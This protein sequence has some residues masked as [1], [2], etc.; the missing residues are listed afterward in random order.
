MLVFVFSGFGYSGFSSRVLSFFGVGFWYLV[1]FESV[2]FCCFGFCMGTLIFFSFGFIYSA[3]VLFFCF[4]ILWL[5]VFW[6]SE[7]AVLC[8]F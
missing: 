2:A 8:W 7:L 5:W 1:L 3:R 4:G 6:I